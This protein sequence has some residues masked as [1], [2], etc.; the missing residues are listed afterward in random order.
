MPSTE[1][2]TRRDASLRARRARAYEGD[3]P[4]VRA[5]VPPTV[6]RILELGC[7][8]GMLGGALKRERD[9]WITGIELDPA[10]ARDAA[11]Q[12]DEVVAADLNSYFDAPA[13][14]A[15]L[16]TFDCLIAADVLEHLSDPW[17]TLAAVARHL[18]PSAVVIVSVP[19]ILYW[20]AL[21]RIAIGGR[22]PREDSGT[23]DRT[24]LHWFTEQDAIELLEVAGCVDVTVHPKIVEQTPLRRRIARAF[25]ST[26]L[27]RFAPGHLLVTGRLGPHSR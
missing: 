17:A 4:D 15:D 7:S 9:V 21:K 13:R 23:F 14:T 16:G 27:A 8:S 25:L 10:F 20:H 19:N 3:R 18:D 12:L 22:W 6:T 11:A 1:A 26:P 2:I 24:H 5:L